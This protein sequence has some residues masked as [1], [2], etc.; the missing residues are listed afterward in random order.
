MDCAIADRRDSRLLDGAADDDPGDVLLAEL[1][2]VVSAVEDLHRDL[3]V[4]AVVDE[5]LPDVLP[6]LR[7]DGVDHRVFRAR[8]R[9][10]PARNDESG[11]SVRTPG[12]PKMFVFSRAPSKSR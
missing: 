5:V 9:P 12:P 3:V 6:D 7:D 10:Q 1:V 8:R 11:D 4:Q 2:A